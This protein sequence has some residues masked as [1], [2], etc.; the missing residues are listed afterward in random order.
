MKRLIL[1]FLFAAAGCATIQAQTYREQFEEFDRNARQTYIDFTV[2]VLLNY[3]EFVKQAWE[4]FEASSPVPMPQDDP[5]P[6]VPYEE[7]VVELEQKSEHRQI[8]QNEDSQL[9]RKEEQQQEQEQKEIKQEEQ[10]QEELQQKEDQQE[11]EQKELNQEEQ[12]QE[13]LQQKED[14]QEQEQKE[15]EQEEQQQEELQQEECHP[16]QEQKEEQE[17]KQDD[18][19]EQQKQLQQEENQQEQEQRELKQEEQLQKELQQE[20]NQQQEQQEQQQE[21]KRTLPIKQQ[22]DRPV[23]IEEVIVIPEPQPAPKPAPQPQPEVVPKNI[24][25]FQIFGTQ[26]EVRI[27]DEKLHLGSTDRT[28]ISQAVENLAKGHY[29]AFVEDCQDL[30]R[31]HQLTD[32]FY[33]RLVDAAV[34]A[35]LE[36]SPDDAELLKAFVLSQS[37]YKT[38]LALDANKHLVMLFGS[39]NILYGKPYWTIDGTY[40]YADGETKG[41]L[42]ICNFA[43]PEE[44]SFTMTIF[45]EPQL[46]QSPTSARTLSVA[47]DKGLTVTVSEDMNLLR[48]LETYPSSQIGSNP[49]TR[50]ALYANMP[51]SAQVRETLYPQLEGQ[52]DGLSVL[53]KL[54]LLLRW[55]QKSLVYEYDDKVWGHDRAFFADETLYYPYADCEDRS[56]L[57][58]RLVRDL[59]GLRVALVY[60]P[61]HLATAVEAPAS[62]KGDHLTI[63]GSRFIVCDPTYIGAPVGRTMRGMDNK[64]AQVLILE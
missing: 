44:Q 50:W 61:G 48:M 27:P 39:G 20:E 12:Q 31:R 29:T 37:G 49:V 15:I 57:F 40:Y 25:R 52:M 14:Q 8:Y 26:M 42:Q 10:Q 24:V 60:Y 45:G 3:A 13:E 38:R 17:E 43:F 18:Q 1:L 11:Q 41:G 55:V 56:I 28:T 47:E 2:R 19:Q 21:E 62:V 63:D 4:T 6:P 34:K 58:S 7:E 35:H 22:E 46:E 30:S 53:A 59:I 33:L 36:D 32:Y 9:P 16:E 23:I 51:L 54:N 5:L 64:S